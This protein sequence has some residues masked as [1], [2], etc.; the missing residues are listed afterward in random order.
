MRGEYEPLHQLGEQSIRGRGGLSATSLFNGTTSVQQAVLP[1]PQ[2]TGV[3]KASIP[4]GTQT[5][6]LL[7]VRANKRLSRGLLFN[8]SYSLGKMMQTRGYR[9]AQYTR[10]TARSPTTTGR[11]TLR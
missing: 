3:T 6:D 5:G 4:N 11:T 7:E 9:E 8:F 10:S 2:F 1:F